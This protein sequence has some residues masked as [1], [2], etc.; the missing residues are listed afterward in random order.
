LLPLCA[1][2]RVKKI[3]KAIRGKD[4]YSPYAEHRIMVEYSI[5]YNDLLDFPY[6][7]YL[8]FSK[9]INLEAKEEKKR[10]DKQERQM[11]KNT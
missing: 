1:E 10:T 4:S 11:E 5:S 6:E 2:E 7:K 8:E 3:K 9:I